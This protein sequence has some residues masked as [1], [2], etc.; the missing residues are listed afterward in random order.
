MCGIKRAYVKI[1]CMKNE[2]VNSPEDEPRIHYRDCREVRDS[3]SST[4]SDEVIRVKRES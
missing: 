1:E 2:N 4:K 3:F